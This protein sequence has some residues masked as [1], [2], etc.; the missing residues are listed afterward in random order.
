MQ[1]IPSSTPDV[2]RFK[3]A[4]IHPGD[5]NARKDFDP[6]EMAE[7]VESMKETR[8]KIGSTLQPLLG[9]LRTDGGVDLIAGERR[10]RAAPAAGYEALEVKIV[11]DCSQADV[12]RWNLVENLQ[13]VGLKP[14][15]TAER[16]VA[17]L[18]LD[19]AGVPVY[20]QA[21]LAAELGKDR[22]FIGWCVM[23][24]KN[25]PK[26]KTA[27]NEGRICLEI[28]AMLGALPE[29]IRE[30]AVKE[31]VFPSWG[32]PPDRDAAR[33][34][35]TENCRRDLRK[36]Q[37]SK[38]DA[39]LVPSAGAC[40]NCP[41][42]GGN[43]DD[44]E[45][46]T[47]ESVCLNPKCCDAKT[48]AHNR[49]IREH[50]EQEGTKV[51][52]NADRIFQNWNN[53]LRPE[54]GYVELKSKPDAHLLSAA[55]TAKT[56]TWE[57]IVQDKGVPVVV[58]FDH[59]G[60]ARRLVETK[61]AIE[62]AKL[63]DH[64]LIFKA[65][66]EKGIQSQDE[67]RE[68][69][70][71]E[72]V[73][74]KAAEQTLI[75]GCGSL[76]QA[77]SAPHGRPTKLALLRQI[78]EAGQTKDDIAMLVLVLK[79]DAKVASD[80]YAQFWELVEQYLPRLEQLDAMIV[81]A[82]NIRSIR[83]N[84]FTHIKEAMEVYCDE[85]DWQPGSWISLMQSRKLKATHAVILK[86]SGKEKKPQPAPTKAPATKEEDAPSVELVIPECVKA[87]GEQRI[88]AWRVYCEVE[89]GRF[90]N[91]KGGVAKRLGIS[92]NTVGNWLKRDDW[93]ALRAQHVKL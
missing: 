21:T 38:Q 60:H 37:W 28:G 49:I 88:A 89:D 77:L 90:I 22:N 4:D 78:T 69:K 14:M 81:L 71:F 40:V 74:K 33:K 44:I 48:E 46:K 68:E 42:W 63:S 83:Y 62:A 54:S 84:G 1:L 58:A 59:K 56:P 79:P 23:A 15:E 39:T 87:G 20:S 75:E 47:R 45:G 27:I 80:A 41:R 55:V 32:E 82:R 26:V 9:K 6:A 64:V 24:V 51:L 93:T 3:L 57:K 65:G 91:G 29:E 13:R 10:L 67:K 7:L 16:V 19:E 61:V 43:R 76:L 5:S 52:N 73:E 8:Q 18:R 31:L 17:M 85:A 72:R 66:A 12:L 70:Q 86:N 2:R 50:A 30:E 11:G 34:Y 36:V 25:S 53:E 92:E 35:I